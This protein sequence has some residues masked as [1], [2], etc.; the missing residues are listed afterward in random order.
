MRP[1]P[2]ANDAANLSASLADLLIQGEDDQRSSEV[3]PV[4]QGCGE[5]DGAKSFSPLCKPFGETNSRPSTY[6]SQH[7]DVLLTLMHISD[8]VA[9][10]TRRRVELIED[11]SRSLIDGFKPSTQCPVEQYAAV[12]GQAVRCNPETCR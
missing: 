8:G 10:N 7:G 1:Q 11:L 2:G 3:R 9:D 12:G 6:A 4:G 5:P